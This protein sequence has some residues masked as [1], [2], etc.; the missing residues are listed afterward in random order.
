VQHN[1]VS[2]PYHNNSYRLG[3][4]LETS[5][6]NTA[7]FVLNGYFNTSDL[8][9]NGASMLNDPSQHGITTQQNVSRDALSLHNAGFNLN[10]QLRIDTAGQTL[11]GDIDIINYR[12]N[13]IAS[14]R[15]FFYLP[16]GSSQQ[17]P[18]Y[19]HEQVPVNINVRTAKADYVFPVSKTLKLETGIKLSDVKTNNNLQAQSSSDNVNFTNNTQLSNQFIYTE[20]IG[21]AYL[22]VLKTIEATDIQFGLRAEQTG[23]TGI[24]TG[25]GANLLNSNYLDLFPNL[26]LNHIIDKNNKVRFNFSSRID[27]PNYQNLNPF[28]YYFDPYTRESGNP[29]LKPQYTKNFEVDYS[30]RQFDLGISYSHTKDVITETVITDTL[31][32]I[33]SETL[34]NLASLNRYN[35]T[36]NYSFTVFNWWTGN[37]NGYLIYNDYNSGNVVGGQQNTKGFSYTAKASQVF[38]LGK[39]DKIELN[40]RYESATIEGLYHIR[41]ASSVDTG[42]SHSFLKGKANLKLSVNDLFNGDKTDVIINTE[43]SHF[44][45]YQK[46]DTRIGRL[47]FTYNFGSSKT[48]SPVH[49]SGADEEKGRAGN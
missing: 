45:G 41:P 47:N 3:A 43:G 19:L 32:K 12:N 48:Q 44:H 21:A 5:T 35:L 30:Y 38:Q 13:G 1:I 11:S 36:A 17:S 27:R 40:G 20:K 28:I 9:N 8:F 26:S 31:T 29:F 34:F 39:N 46:Y 22:N 4:V 6:R 37:I 23:S 33:S 15:T 42:I 2:D 24:L 14:F 25:G 7:G 16:D 18:S 49:Q 10:D